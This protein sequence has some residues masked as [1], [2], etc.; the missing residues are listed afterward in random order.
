[1][2]SHFVPIV[3][4]LCRIGEILGSMIK[5]VFVCVAIRAKILIPESVGNFTVGRNAE[6]NECRQYANTYDK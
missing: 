6:R 1:M 5:L 4:A 2:S 3:K